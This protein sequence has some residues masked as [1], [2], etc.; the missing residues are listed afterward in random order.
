MVQLIC[1]GA[2]NLRSIANSSEQNWGPLSLTRICWT[3]LQLKKPLKAWMVF[4][5]IVLTVNTSGH[6]GWA[7]MPTSYMQPSNML[8]KLMC[9]FSH[10][11][12]GHIHG[13]RN[14]RHGTIC[15][16]WQSPAIRYYCMHLLNWI[17]LRQLTQ[18]T[19]KELRIKGLDQ[20]PNNGSLV[21]KQP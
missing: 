19:T 10:G 20:G 11:L 13:W 12:V 5:I 21:V 9:I 1:F 7:S 8:A 4:L 3:S 16:Q 6:V 15:I 17:Q 2:F 18:D 14:A